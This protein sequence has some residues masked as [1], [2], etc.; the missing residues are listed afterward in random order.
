MHCYDTIQLRIDLYL[1][2]KY[3]H[4]YEYLAVCI[5]MFICPIVVS[6]ILNNIK[7]H[8][9]G[10]IYKHQFVETVSILGRHR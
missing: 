4:V 3:E 1:M 7:S 5:I 9:A 2:W 8:N 10:L 6:S